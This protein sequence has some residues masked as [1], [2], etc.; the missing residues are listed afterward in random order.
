MTPEP[1][2]NLNRMRRDA[3]AIFLDALK[4]V[5]PVSSVR[6][7]LKTNGA[8]LSAGAL[9]ID[10]DKVRHLYVVGAGKASA[11]MASALEALLPGRITG[12]CIN[13]KYGHTAPLDTIRL[14]ESGHPVPDAEGLRGTEEILSLVTPAGPEDLIICLISGGGSSL[15]PLPAPGLSLSMKQETTRALLACGAT[16]HEINTVRKHLSAVKGGQ[17]AR[18]AFPAPLITLILSDVVGDD[19]DVIASGPTVPDRSTYGD[20]L[21]LIEKYDLFQKLPEPVLTHLRK[22]AAGGLPETPKPGDVIFESTCNIVIGSNR[23][24]LRAARRSAVEKGYHTRV[25][26]ATVEGEAREV[27]RD[28]AAVAKKAAG[29][30]GDVTPPAC[31]LSGGETTVTLLGNGKGGRN[32]EFVLAAA[33]DIDQTSGLVIFSAGT[34][35]TDGPTDAAG[36]VADP[37]TV[38]RA[39]KIG[40]DPLSYLNHNDAYH[41]FEKLGDLVITGPTNTNVMD[42]R[43]M[44]IS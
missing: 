25:L 15:M 20:C 22:G 10:L 38:P 5:S 11:A 24:A 43:I 8:T 21:G 39:R 40:M 14:V 1:P 6:K 30:E 13:V 2:P 35:G 12:G 37:E 4:A 26:S 17:L 3:L 28:H 36:A 27:A 44:L 33:L 19:L 41:F 16:I 9:T 31:I 18:A 34:D 7:H 23:D 32:Q 42:L 29:G